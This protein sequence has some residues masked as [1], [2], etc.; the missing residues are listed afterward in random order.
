MIEWAFM[1]NE[2]AES[3]TALVKIIEEKK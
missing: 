2:C 3:K 1:Y